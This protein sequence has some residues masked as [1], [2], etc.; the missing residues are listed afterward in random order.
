M[1]R[2]SIIAAVALGLLGL[3]AVG[4]LAVA[5]S[6]GE[7]R[8]GAIGSRTV[9][10][11]Y[12]IQINGQ[13]W[14]GV[15]SLSG[16]R[17]RSDVI[18]AQSQGAVQKQLTGV[19][20][21]P[22]VMELRLSNQTGLLQWIE[23]M[24]D[25]QAERRN[26]VLIRSNPQTGKRLTELEL[27]DALITQVKFPLLDSGSTSKVSDAELTIVPEGIDRTDYGSSGPNMPGV[28]GLKQFNSA[29]FTFDLSGI[30]D[31]QFTTSLESFVVTQ[32][33][34]VGEIDGLR[35]YV[36][37]PTSLETGDLEMSIGL[38]RTSQLEDWFEEFVIDGDNGQNQEKTATLTFKDLQ[39]QNTFFALQFD[40]V[41]VFDAWDVEATGSTHTN[42]ARRAYA[43]YVEDVS[44]TVPGAPPPAGGTTTTATTTATTT[45]A[46]T[47]TATTTTAATTTAAPPPPAPPAEPALAAPEGLT[48]KLSSASD[49]QLNWNAVKGA[50]GYIVLMSQKPGGEYTELLR[51]KEPTATVSKLEGGPPYYFVVRA[52]AAEEESENSDEAEAAG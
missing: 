38:N 47:T 51:T 24:V 28:P 48:A 41:G 10:G 8:V 44:M 18:T 9:S 46:T 15:Q 25:G 49:A 52:F 17:P 5:L 26:V 43:M 1:S 36:T 45:T 42:L 20:F 4:A 32:K 6:D 40:G 13:S 31:A 7:R 16:C 30:P 50:E 35:T 22:C 27:D 33:T 39:T 29:G 3:A 19:R 37:E 14:G 34:T 2:R 21:E 12:V 11:T 23:A